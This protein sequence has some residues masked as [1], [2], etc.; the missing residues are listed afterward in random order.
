MQLP[1]AAHQRRLGLRLAARG[2]FRMFVG[3]PFPHSGRYTDTHPV[4]GQAQEFQQD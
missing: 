3:N 4:G 2:N 1:L